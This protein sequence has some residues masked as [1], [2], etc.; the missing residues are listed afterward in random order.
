MGC[1]QCAKTRAEL[2]AALTRGR[3]ADIIR[4]ATKGARQMAAHALG[5]TP[6]R[7]PNVAAN[8]RPPRR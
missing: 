6:A 5:R 2:R 7:P 3:P 4:I 8:R 1:S